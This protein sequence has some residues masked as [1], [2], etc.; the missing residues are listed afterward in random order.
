MS[1]G[2]LSLLHQVFQSLEGPAVTALR[3]FLDFLRFH[4][5]LSP[6]TV[7]SYGADL[8]QWYLFL[9]SVLGRSYLGL[10]DLSEA[11]LRRFVL[12]RHP[13]L[14]KS[15][16]AR[17]LATYRSFFRFLQERHELAHNPGRFLRSPKIRV[18]LPAFL[19]VDDTLAF[20]NDLQK[21]AQAPSA[22]WTTA[23]DWALFETLYAT[24][25]RVGE[26][27]RLN[28]DHLDRQEGIVR[29]VGKGSKERVVPIGSK[30]LE[31]IGR[32]LEAFRGQWRGPYDPKAVFLN[33]RGG[34]LSDRSVRRLMRQRLRD[35]GQWR[36]LSPHGLRHS[37][38]TH[39]LSSGA[40][41]RSIQEMLG[42]A[43]LSTTQRYTKVDVDQIM[44]VYEDAHPRSRKSPS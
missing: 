3:N 29:A 26:L 33:A 42:H 4:R 6:A 34:R 38:A 1:H 11:N 15:S 40:D 16:Q 31:A 21:K 35:A 37:F 2:T 18:T 24:G 9:Q 19:D 13:R 44:R 41:L 7:Q 27:V 30:A 12:H 10:E 22:P 8:A 5:T 39:L 28:H 20:L 14:A 43:R 32:Y 25:L 17:A 36:P 23:R